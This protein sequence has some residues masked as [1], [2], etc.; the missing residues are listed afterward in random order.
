[1]SKLFRPSF[2]SAIIFGL[3]FFGLFTSKVC[4][5][6]GNSIT[7]FVFN[8]NRQ[9]VPEVYV[10]LQNDMYSVLA[11]AKTTSS[12]FFA[13]RGLRDGSYNVKILPLGTDYQEQTRSVSLV[14]FSPVQGKGAISEQVDFYLQ[15]K[16]NQNGG[17]TL[18]VSGVI[19]A[20]D[21]PDDAKKFYEEGVRLIEEKKEAEGFESLKKALEIFPDYF[22]AL[23]KLGTEYILRGFYQP[24]Y[25]LLSKAVRINP[26]SFTSTFGLGLAQ[27]RLREYAEAEKSLKMA[28]QLDGESA[29][30]HLWLGIILHQNGKL[31][32]S[33]KSLLFANKLTNGEADEVHFQLARLYSDQKRYK[34]AANELEL[35]LKYSPDARDKEKILE[36]IQKLRQKAGGGSE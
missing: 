34:D 1:M 10:E 35:F 28:T 4:A 6:A 24:S 33:E 2:V 30:G 26:K 17:E 22:L 25:E 3:S 18:G 13:F 29:N 16:K 31:A 15:A 23:D 20:Q 9:P 32:E 14:S 19:F 12:G 27:Y 8:S 36:T 7:G 21:I 5:Q 11:R